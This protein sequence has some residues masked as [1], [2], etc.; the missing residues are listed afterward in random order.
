M[1][2]S[3]ITVNKAFKNTHVHI[4]ALRD[5]R[6]GPVATLEPPNNIQTLLVKMLLA[7]V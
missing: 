7:N 5:S 4:F 2:S 3:L 6:L 1:L